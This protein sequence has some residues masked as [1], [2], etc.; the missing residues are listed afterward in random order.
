MAEEPALEETACMDTM[1]AGSWRGEETAPA[2]VEAEEG[3]REVTEAAQ[4]V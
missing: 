1:A 2:A 4:E 3:W